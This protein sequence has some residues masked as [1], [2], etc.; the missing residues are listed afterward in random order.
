MGIPAYFKYITAQYDNLI[1]KSLD[2]PVSRLFLD[3][4]GAIHPKAQKIL[5]EYPDLKNKSVLENK[6]YFE[7]LDY[8][9]FLIE[10]VQPNDTLFISIDGVAPRAK[11]QQ[12]RSRRFKSSKEKKDKK[13]IYDKYNVPY[14]LNEWDTNAITPGTEFMNGISKYLKRELKKT[15]YNIKIILSD[16]NDPSEGEHKIFKY[17]KKNP[18]EGIDIVYGLDADLIMLS[19][20]CKNANIL[21]LRESLE[22]GNMVNKDELGLP[23]LLYLDI[24]EFKKSIVNDLTENGLKSNDSYRIICDYICL[25]FF[26]GNDFL[27]HSLSLAI[28]KGGIN[29]LLEYYLEIF[30]TN[31]TKH[32]LV[33]VQK[34]KF[35]I[36][37]KF[38]YKLVCKI[39]DSENELLELN[40][41]DVLKSKVHYKPFKNQLEKELHLYNYLPVFNREEDKYIILGSQNWRQ[42]YYEVCFD[43][44]YQKDIDQI[45]INYLEGLYWILK[46]YFEDCISYN[47][48]YRYNHPPAMKDIRNF[49]ENNDFD[50]N[51]S[52]KIDKTPYTPFVQL[53]SVLPPSSYKLVPSSYQ[54]LFNSQQSPILDLYPTNFKL[55]TLGKFQ[56][57][58]CPPIIPVVDDERIL[59][60]TQDLPLNK[61]E[62]FRNGNRRR[63]IIKD[64]E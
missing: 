36:N 51:K 50:I 42:R 8:I 16:S 25:C 60:A 32:Y 17:I 19:M 43:T 58:Q 33:N 3:L 22:F 9:K 14:N 21:L 35:T 53:M 28:K 55:D 45:C 54:F 6:I 52:V 23:L 5:S 62:T 13:Y 46:Y 40:T 10:Y 20:T 31:D 4:N 48:F 1:I 47:W 44:E 12:Q 24:S 59:E 18:I 15:K 29:I 49:L 63:I 37:N 38:L 64:K 39:T 34:N 30:N 57:W 11:M 41:K 7:V 61:E 56:T 26:L 27:P 2:N